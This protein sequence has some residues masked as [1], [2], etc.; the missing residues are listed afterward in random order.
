M[1]NKEKHQLIMGQILKDIYTDT[2]IS[3]L[4]GFKG[5]TCAYF[6]Y[7]LPR[8]SV[9]LDFDL[10]IV[11]EKNKKIIFEKITSILS[12]Y[13]K[14]K[15]KHIKNFTIFALLSYEKGEHNIKLEINTKETI[16]NISKHYETKERLGIS[17]LVAKK[18][19][20]FASKLAALSSRNETAMRDV[21]DIHYFAKNNWD[22]NDKVIEERSK[23]NTEKYLADCI[24]FIEKIENNQIL[25]G[26]GELVNSEKEKAWIKNHLKNDSIFMLKN[27]L[28]IISKRKKP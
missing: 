25:K 13:G 4:L 3:P 1:L 2:T 10:L 21:Y 5:G 23:K 18:D 17:T 27:Y 14:L 6:F 9:D 22:I 24:N 16:K 26:L 28:S 20:M 15:D 8:F 12:K 7:N 11:S 19:Y